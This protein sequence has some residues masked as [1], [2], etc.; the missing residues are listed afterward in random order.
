MTD[1]STE[2]RRHM[3]KRLSCTANVFQTQNGTPLGRIFDISKEGF[4]LL[5]PSKVQPKE[6]INLT[7]EL[8][9]MDNTRAIELSAECMWCQPSSFTKDFGAG[10]HIKNIS[11]QDQVALNY[12]IRDF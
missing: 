6:V 2:Q 4:M 12:F 7:L 11:D 1:T 9:E 10:F 3:R 5:S 8:P